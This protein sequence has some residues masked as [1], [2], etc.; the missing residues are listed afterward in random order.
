MRGAD[1]L[2]V[3]V[4][5]QIKSILEIS[6][7]NWIAD[8]RLSIEK[9]D[10]GSC[11]QKRSNLLWCFC[12]GSVLCALNLGGLAVTVATHS[13]LVKVDLFWVR[14]P[15]GVVPLFPSGPCWLAIPAYQV[16]RQPALL[17]PG[18][19]LGAWDG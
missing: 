5:F 19:P 8:L 2:D 1:R 13:G 12:A 14:R 9:E 10:R 7:D 18:S 3:R 16:A 15:R 17:G 6:R 11:L 4:A